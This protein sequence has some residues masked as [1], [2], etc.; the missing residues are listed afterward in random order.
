M[1]CIIEKWIRNVTGRRKQNKKE[2]RN[3]NVSIANMFLVT[4]FKQK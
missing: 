3:V 1:F 4:F 2:E